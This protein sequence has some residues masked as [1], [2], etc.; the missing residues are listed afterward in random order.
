MRHLRQLALPAV[1]AAALLAAG[2]GGGGGGGAG[3]STGS[4]ETTAVDKNSYAYE[5]GFQL[6]ST[7]TIEELALEYGVEP[8]PDLIAKATAEAI[9]GGSGEKDFEAGRQGCL[10]AF[11][12]GG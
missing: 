1:A 2:C 7:G 3:G 9:A 8:K 6:C 5:G 11:A 12:K 10:D 4:G